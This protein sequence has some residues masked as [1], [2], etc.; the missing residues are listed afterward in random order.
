MKI[1]L[2][3]VI[4]GL[5]IGTLSAYECPGH[6]RTADDIQREC[7]E[8]DVGITNTRKMLDNI[9]PENAPHTVEDAKNF[10]EIS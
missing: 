8:K 6:P 2:L 7:D 10:A 9:D 3:I 1:I 4:S 5:Y